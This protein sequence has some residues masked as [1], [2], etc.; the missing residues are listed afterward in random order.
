M[1]RHHWHGCLA[2][3]GFV[4]SLIFIAFWFITDDYSDNSMFMIFCGM[5]ISLTGNNVI[6]CLIEKNLQEKNISFCE[7]RNYLKKMGVINVYT[8]IKSDKFIII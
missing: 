3:G 2:F 7:Y 1:K 5:S 6:T 8:S 4:A